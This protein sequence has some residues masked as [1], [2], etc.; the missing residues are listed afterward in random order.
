LS[1]EERG[2]HAKSALDNP[3]VAEALS[4]VKAEI[5]KMFAES[6]PADKEA[7]EHYW[8]LH[9]VASMFERVLMGY[10]RTGQLETM[11]AQETRKQRAIGALK[12]F[13][14]FT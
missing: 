3:A 14:N 6:K 4:A 13:G 5:F 8:R 11:K 9:E 7:R 1:P 12:R 2:E 10:F